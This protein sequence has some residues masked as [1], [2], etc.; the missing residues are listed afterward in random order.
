MV[1]GGTVPETH[2]HAGSN[3]RGLKKLLKN[4]LARSIGTRP[5]GQDLPASVASEAGPGGD[6][7]E[8]TSA[9]RGYQLW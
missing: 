9:H 4:L 8:P 3:G 1:V 7:A 2:R 6:V 5:E